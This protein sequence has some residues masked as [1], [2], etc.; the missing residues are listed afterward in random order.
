MSRSNAASKMMYLWSRQ[1]WLEPTQ[2]EDP[3]PD[4]SQPFI[5]GI[6]GSPRSNCDRSWGRT[7]CMKYQQKFHFQMVRKFRGKTQR[8]YADHQTHR[9]RPILIDPTC[10]ICQMT[11]TMRAMCKAQHRNTCAQL[12][13]SKNIGRVDHCGSRKIEARS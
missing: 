2:G 8:L 1:K 5:E 6:C 12:V 7:W 11:K 3:L 10:K 4:C 13:S 9:V